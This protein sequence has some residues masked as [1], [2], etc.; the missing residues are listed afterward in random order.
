MI[1][2]PMKKALLQSLFFCIFIITI[3]YSEIVKKVKV[4]G[5]IRVSPETIVLFGDI[6]VN[7]DYNAQKINELS[8]QLYDTNFFSYLEINLNNGILEISV[9]ENPI[10]QSLILP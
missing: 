9:K 2:C 3:S 1:S 8:K 5:N 10:I 6:R 7:E 4:V